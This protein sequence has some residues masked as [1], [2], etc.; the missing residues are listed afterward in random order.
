MATETRVHEPLM[1]SEE[2]GFRRATRRNLIPSARYGASCTRPGLSG[3]FVSPAVAQLVGAAD[4][5]ARGMHPPREW[6]YL[7]GDIHPRYAV[8]TRQSCATPETHKT[9]GLA[10]P[11]LPGDAAGAGA[12]RSSRPRGGV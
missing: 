11:R 6:Q 5:L 10:L 7:D 3:N 2:C 12:G 9:G 4:A 8:S 1:I